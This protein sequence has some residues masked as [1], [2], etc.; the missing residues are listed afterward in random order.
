MYPYGMADR[1]YDIPFHEEAAGRFDDEEPRTACEEYGHV[2]FDYDSN[3]LPH[4]RECLEPSV[5]EPP[6]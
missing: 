5:D 3:T 1:Y 6:C 4:C 2:F